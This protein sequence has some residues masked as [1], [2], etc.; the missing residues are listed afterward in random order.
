MQRRNW[1][2]RYI[3]KIPS[4]DLLSLKG[5]SADCREWNLK[6]QT[7][8]ND[9]DIDFL[10]S[11][12]CSSFS[13][14]FPIRVL[15]V[16]DGNIEAWAKLDRDR[17][18][19]WDFPSIIDEIEQN[20]TICDASSEPRR[21]DDSTFFQREKSVDFE[22]TK[23]T[24]SMQ[25]ATNN[26]LTSS[27]PQHLAQ[28]HTKSL[29]SSGLFFDELDESYFISQARPFSAFCFVIHRILLQSRLL[30]LVDDTSLKDTAVNTTLKNISRIGYPL[31]S[32]LLF[33]PHIL[34]NVEY[35]LVSGFK[36]E[37]DSSLSC[38]MI[39]FNVFDCC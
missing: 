32:Q 5:K 31:I 15:R 2:I 37:P 27:H 22:R 28:R 19:D 16:P 39:F 35:P 26:V 20:E 3:Q 29:W 21:P 38:M 24:K 11:Y 13:S 6:Q 34:R 8:E 4:R 9:C 10:L 12:C 14:L 30:L 1:N 7:P 36:L 25:N 23:L 33:C 18:R 17:D